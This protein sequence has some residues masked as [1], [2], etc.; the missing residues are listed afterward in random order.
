MIFT[1]LE[2]FESTQCNCRA[3]SFNK[4]GYFS[5]PKNIQKIS[6]KKERATWPDLFL[7]RVLVIFDEK[8]REF[9]DFC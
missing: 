9:Q 7:L 6:T 4:E 8:M 2:N 1:T 5:H 3:N